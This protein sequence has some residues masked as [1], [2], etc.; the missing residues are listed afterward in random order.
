MKVT[1]VDS[2][3]ATTTS[4]RK[5]PTPGAGESFADHLQ[6]VAAASEGTA[7]VESQNVT[8]V[9]SIVAVQETPD[10]TEERSRG[11]LRQYGDNVLDRLDDL[12]RQVLLGV[13][14]KERLVDLART[15][16]TRRQ[17]TEDPRLKEIIDEIELR[18]EVEIA[19]L[20]R[21]V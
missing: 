1:R 7:F 20:T 19:K 13:V 18:A 10:A 15:L 21:D 4:R 12:R 5:S 2:S 6:E 11:L 3:K 8:A 16:R 14:S 9:E 17:T